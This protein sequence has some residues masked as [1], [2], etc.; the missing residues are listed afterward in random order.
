MKITYRPINIGDIPLKTQWLNDS[1]VRKYLGPNKRKGVKITEQRKN[2]L[3]FQKD[4][5]ILAFLIIADGKPIGEVSL[6]RINIIDKNACIFIMIGEKS[7]WGKGIGKDALTYIIDYGF[8]KLKLHK[9]YL[10][11]FTANTAAY[12]CYQSVGFQDEGTL[13]DQA[14][15][16]NHFVDEK[17]MALINK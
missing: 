14:F 10:D 7:Y 13:K 1:D 3:K 15:I 6:T 2:F 11:V 4:K 12:K 8:N 17:R 5:S 9:L 16:D